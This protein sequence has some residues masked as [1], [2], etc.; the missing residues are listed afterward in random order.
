MRADGRSY[1]LFRRGHAFAVR[2]KDPASPARLGFRGLAYFPID[3]GWRVRG[4][5]ERYDP[6]RR[7]NHQYDIGGDLE[8]RVPGLAHFEVGGQALT[9]EPVLEEGSGRLFVL[10]GDASNRDETYPAG[11][12]L[13]AELPAGDE[14]VLDFNTAFNPPCAFTPFATCPLLQPQN[15]LPLRIDAGEKRYDP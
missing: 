14:I 13:Y 1:E 2:V 4:R 9:L 11:R 15:R 6:P 10:F 7:T 12:F 5:F 3:L 8:R